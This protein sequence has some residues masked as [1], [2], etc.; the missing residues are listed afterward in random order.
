MPPPKKGK[1]GKKKKKGPPE[2]TRFK[3]ISFA[4]EGGV[5][6]APLAAAMLRNLAKHTIIDPDLGIDVDSFGL[7][8]FHNSEMPLPA[9]ETC[10]QT[11]GI[12]DF[13]PIKPVHSM[14]KSDFTRNNHIIVME[15]EDINRIEELRTKLNVTSNCTAK[16]MLISEFYPPDC[17]LPKNIPDVYYT[18]DKQAEACE[19]VYK[20]FEQAI[21]NIMEMLIAKPKKT[22]E[23]DD[24]TPIDG[25]NTDGNKD[26]TTAKDSPK[27]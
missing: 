15:E 11:H 14:N 21:P 25:E 23:L 24:D 27:K 5:A 3:F 4:S 22:L 8:P 16:I 26:E 17:K 6:R 7:T 10:C 1:K 9:I 2:P 18:E 13:M 20:M 19:E 12:K